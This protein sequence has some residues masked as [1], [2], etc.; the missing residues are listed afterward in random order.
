[1]ATPLW[2]QLTGLALALSGWTKVIY[3]LT[4]SK[5]RVSGRIMNIMR[6]QA[7]MLE[8]EDQ[9]FTS[10]TAYLY[11]VN[12]RKSSIHLLDYALEARVGKKWV[13]LGRWYALH[14][15]KELT[16]YAPDGAPIVIER[17]SDHLIYRKD[18]AAE[19]G[20]PLHG[21]AIFLGPADLHMADIAEYRLRC[22]DAFANTHTIK[23]VP[24]E[25]ADIA[26][27]EE[28]TPIRIPASARAKT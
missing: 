27:L 23:N 13:K 6:G 1:M 17:F 11:V 4:T 18:Q 21:W 10:F 24:S 9:V 22:I 2:I 28:L 14:N 8:I 7:R 25:F 19:Y 3:D 26:L 5:P 20:K 16:F 12:T 15:L